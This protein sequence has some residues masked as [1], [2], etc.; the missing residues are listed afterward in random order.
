M[1]VAFHRKHENRVVRAVKR[2][3]L[4]NGRPPLQYVDEVREERTERFRGRGLLISAVLLY[5]TLSGT[6]TFGEFVAMEAV[7][8]PG[9][10]L[11]NCF[12]TVKASAD[13]VQRSQIVQTCEEQFSNQ[14]SIARYGLTYSQWLGWVMPLNWVN[15]LNYFQVSIDNLAFQ[16][17]LFQVTVDQKAA[18]KTTTS[19]NFT[20][21]YKVTVTAENN[22]VL[23]QSTVSEMQ[24][25]G[26]HIQEQHTSKVKSDWFIV[27]TWE[28]VT[29]TTVVN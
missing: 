5:L 13:S 10:S 23:L 8:N 28:K 2:S 12:N 29:V 7:K 19:Q 16:R 22:P 24:A 14:V 4:G 18:P 15:Y 25:A 17:N 20:Y 26:Y 21:E 27:T 11:G 6:V 3:Y 1:R 9:F